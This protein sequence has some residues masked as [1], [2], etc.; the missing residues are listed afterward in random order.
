MIASVLLLLSASWSAVA[1]SSA[2]TSKSG[3]V[4]QWAQWEIALEAPV[5]TLANPFTSVDLMV[6]L[7]APGGAVDRNSVVRG[8]YDGLAT[9]VAAAGT[10]DSAS[11]GVWRARF[12]PPIVGTWTWLTHCS[13]GVLNNKS[14][15]FT[16]VPPSSASNHGPVRTHG[17]TFRYA[18]GKP[19]HV[20]G[21]TV[22]GLSG[23]VWGSNK[24]TPNK[25]AETLATL[26]RSPFNKVRMMAF[27]TD[28]RSSAPTW[29]PYEMSS[30]HPNQTDP[31]RFNLP[32]WQRLDRTIGSLLELGI[33]ADIILFNLYSPPWPIGLSCLGGS[34]PETY[35]IS[36]DRLFLRYMVARIASFRNV[37]W[38]M[39][40]EWNQCS[41]KFTAPDPDHAEAAKPVGW[42][43]AA[44]TPAWDTPIWDELF[45]IVRATFVCVLCMV[46]ICQ[47][48]F[49]FS[50]NVSCCRFM[51]RTQAN[52]LCQSTTTHT[53]ITTPGHGSAIS[54]SSTRTTSR[55]T[56]GRSTRESRS[57]GM[58]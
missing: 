10:A 43:P 14:G 29:L 6:E 45:R 18:D 37:W 11:V 44:A 51:L 35:N 27:P 26:A 58:R 1:S 50:Y 7:H 46:V 25:T 9:T 28:G 57:C 22:Y 39:S 49:H 47:L 36:N 32:F 16:V 38:S 54:A 21:T 2:M 5:H 15:A 41:C 12:M 20:V 3:A 31:T 48:L 23:G 4:E 55:K 17:T 40:N 8:F 53:C 33:Q 19:F 42:P 56:C 13:T 34:T 24:L 30:S 52:I